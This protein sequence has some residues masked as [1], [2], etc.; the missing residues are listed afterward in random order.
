MQ[1]IFYSTPA[2]F[3]AEMTSRGLE[4]LWRSGAASTY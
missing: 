1:A 3:T 2:A 4:E